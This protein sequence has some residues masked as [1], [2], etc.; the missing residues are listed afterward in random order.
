[1]ARPYVAD[2]GT[3]LAA[4]ILTKQSRT[5]D[6]EWSSSLGLGEVLMASHRKKLI[7]LQNIAKSLGIR[8]MKGALCSVLLTKCYSIDQIKK[9]EMGRTCSTWVNGKGHTGL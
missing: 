6:K 3:V 8:L 5:A 9:T 2:Q 7:T 1:M 4:N